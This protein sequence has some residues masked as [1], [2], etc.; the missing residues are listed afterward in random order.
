MWGGSQDLD[1]Q[2]YTN[3]FSMVEGDRPLAWDPLS[4]Y[5]NGFF[6]YHNK[7]L[8]LEW[9]DDPDSRLL[10]L[11]MFNKFLFFQTTVFVWS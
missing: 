2:H 11:N 3:F 1:V 5:C 6:K 10:I 4:R 8:F 7:F 9:I